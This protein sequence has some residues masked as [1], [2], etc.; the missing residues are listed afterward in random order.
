MCWANPYRITVR[1]LA[2]IFHDTVRQQL[3]HNTWRN[4]DYLRV[5]EQQLKFVQVLRKHGVTVMILGSIAGI[6]SQHYTRDIGFCID[7]AFFPARM[8]TPYRAPEQRALEKF[9]PRLSKVVRLERGR[10]EGG[11]VMVYK[12]KVLAGLGEATDTKGVTELQ[13]KLAE[14][15]SPREVVPIPFAQRGVIHLDTKFNLV[16]EDVALFARKCFQP[17]T[18]RWLE[19][20][21][22]LIE[23]T[24]EEAAGLEINTLAIG[25]GKVVMQARSERLA[26]EVQ[27]RGLAPILLDY[28]EVTRWPGSF[29]CTTLPL[30][31]AG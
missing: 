11:D 26:K 6:N 8:G 9:I 13:R 3:Q 7:E 15:G 10:I 28:S 18:V 16:G 27:R 23:A 24:D 25:N 17:D 5:R 2:S 31:R 22:D 4:F 14:L 21:F 1:L 12:D 19:R 29:R 20:H 30:K